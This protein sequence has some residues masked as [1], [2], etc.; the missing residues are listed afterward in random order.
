MQIAV[1][2]VQREP[3]YLYETLR[4]LQASTYPADV[5]PIDVFIGTPNASKIEEGL[6]AY[7]ETYAHRIGVDIWNLIEPLPPKLRAV[8]N[9]VTALASSDD[10]LMLF[11]DDIA[12]KPGWLDVLVDLR[13]TSFDAHTFISLY[14]HRDLRPHGYRP[15][16]LINGLTYEPLKW[17][18]VEFYG[19]LGLF[20]PRAHR[21]PLAKAAGIH[22]RPTDPRPVETRW[23]FDEIVKIYVNDHR[24]C[25]LAISIPSYVDHRGDV[26]VI[27]PTHGIRRAPMF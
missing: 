15:E 7:P 10:D 25:S 23:P 24:A 26:S 8:G 12:I 2:T 6:T 4:Q 19:T 13:E 11:E 20:V 18:I 14:S 16:N 21:K 17:P 22:L 1:I 5:G 3:M 9:F 27:N